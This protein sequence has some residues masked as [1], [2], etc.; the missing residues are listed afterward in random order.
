MSGTTF[1]NKFLSFNTQNI[2]KPLD[3][4]LS[5]TPVF[6]SVDS[7]LHIDLREQ[8]DRNIRRDERYGDIKLPK[9]DAKIL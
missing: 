6:M 8:P 9:T 5:D 7:A 1:H 4:T 2:V 3:P